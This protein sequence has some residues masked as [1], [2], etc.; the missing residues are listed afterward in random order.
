MGALQ[1]LDQADSRCLVLDQHQIDP[2]AVF[3]LPKD[4]LVLLDD[5]GLE[6]WVLQ[7]VLPAV[8]DQ[9]RHSTVHWLEYPKGDGCGRVVVQFLGE[10]AVVALQDKL[11]LRQGLVG[12]P[13]LEPLSLD[14]PALFRVNDL[15][16]DLLPPKLGSLVLQDLLPEAWGEVVEV[17]VGR[18]GCQVNVVAFPA[19]QVNNQV[20]RLGGGRRKDAGSGETNPA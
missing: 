5:L 7:A 15:G 12:R 9:D 17:G 8:D 14:D 16:I 2:L 10:G 6:V 4:S 13:E 3:A 18:G 19:D 11:Q 20:F 1:V